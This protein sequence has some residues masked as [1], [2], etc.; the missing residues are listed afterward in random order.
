MQRLH[1]AHHSYDNSVLE[2]WCIEMLECELHSSTGPP[3]S[4]ALLVCDN[5]CQKWLFFLSSKVI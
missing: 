4:I 5:H 1:S 2:D 3:H